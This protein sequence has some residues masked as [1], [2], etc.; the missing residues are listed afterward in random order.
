MI[1]RLKSEEG[2]EILGRVRERVLD[3]VLG[4]KAGTI[5]DDFLRVSPAEV[6]RIA[7]GA[8]SHTRNLPVFREILAGEIRATLSELGVRSVGDVLAEAH[9]LEATRALAIAWLDPA[10][11]EMARSEVFGRWLG[12]LLAQTDVTSG[13]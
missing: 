6:A 3:R 12:D 5:V 1:E 9:L 13:T 7:E 11:A 2:R 8:V 10:I 4:T